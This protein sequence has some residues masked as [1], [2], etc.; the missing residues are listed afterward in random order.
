MG[1]RIVLFAQFAVGVC[2]GRVEVAETDGAQPVG[3]AVPAEHAFEKEFGLRVGAERV[4]GAV[5]NQRQLR[6][7]PINGTAGGEDEFADTCIQQRVEKPQVVGYVVPVVFARRCSGFAH[8]GMRGE[9]QGPADTVLGNGYADQRG[10]FDAAF[11][12]GSEAD[13]GTIAGDEVVDDY[14]FVAGCL[15]R[16][17]REVDDEA[18]DAS[19]ENRFR[20]SENPQYSQTKK[21]AAGEGDAPLQLPV[22]FR[23]A[24]ELFARRAH[25]NQGAAEQHAQRSG[26]GGH[27]VDRLEVEGRRTACV[28]GEAI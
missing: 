9:Q 6:L 12:E 2:A 19:Y 10:V 21:S 15:Q 3:A 1:F 28:E 27:R 5:F 22:L 20:H 4:G 14:G 16:F 13:R 18:C 23:L 8:V 7:R 26:F 24:R 25:K 11:M 17:S